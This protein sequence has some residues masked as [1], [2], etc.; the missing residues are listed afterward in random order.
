[1]VEGRYLPFFNLKRETDIYLFTK[2]NYRVKTFTC[3][4]KSKN[5]NAVL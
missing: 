3:K 4:E 5:N 1:M 2:S